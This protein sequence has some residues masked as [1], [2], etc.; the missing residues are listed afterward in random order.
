[1]SRFNDYAGQRL[2][3][4]LWAQTAGQASGGGRTGYAPR[5]QLAEVD[6]ERLEDPDDGWSARVRRLGYLPTGPGAPVARLDWREYPKL[7]E[8]T[9]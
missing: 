3:R 9:S 1:M 6:E 4:K 2:M 7:T 8:L 5:W